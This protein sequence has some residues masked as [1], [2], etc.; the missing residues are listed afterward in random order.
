M[1]LP[2]EHRHSEGETTETNV[3]TAPAFHGVKNFLDKTDSRLEPATSMGFHCVQVSTR[4]TALRQNMEVPPRCQPV[5]R[6]PV[7]E[8]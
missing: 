7:N 1:E 8:K 4:G 6:E 3:F 5:H 2:E